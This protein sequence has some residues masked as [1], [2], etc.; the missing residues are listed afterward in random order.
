MTTDVWTYDQ[1]YKELRTGDVILFSGTGRSPC[2]SLLGV[3]SWIRECTLSRWS[4]I[5]MVV[6]TDLG[7]YSYDIPMLWESNLGRGHVADL[8]T[9]KPKSG[10]RL[11]PLRQRLESYVGV[12]LA[13]RPLLVSGRSEIEDEEIRSA[14]NRKLVTDQFLLKHSVINYDLHWTHFLDGMVE[15]VF[16]VK[17]N[18]LEVGVTNTNRED[19]SKFCSALIQYTYR[20]LGITAPDIPERHDF[21]VLPTHFAVEEKPSFELRFLPPFSLGKQYYI[22]RRDEHTGAL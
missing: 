16:G 3:S 13:W 1:I 21:D 2:L 12:Q 7:P 8:L 18:V 15:D 10:A 5:G 19:Q 9:G 20:Y 6:R 14:L 11:V 4:H 17:Q 22:Q